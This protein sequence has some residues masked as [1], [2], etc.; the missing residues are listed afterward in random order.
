MS[1]LSK[2]SK[3]KIKKPVNIILYGQGG[4]GKS[5]FPS[6]A[7]NP[8]YLGPETEGGTAWL[9]VS[10]FPVPKT[11]AEIKNSLVELLNEKH[12]FKTL[13]FD[14]LD[15]TEPLIFQSVC[16]EAKVSLIEDAYGGFGKGYVRALD[17]WR[18]MI[19]LIHDLQVQRQMHFVAIAHAQVK[20]HTDPKTQHTWNRYTMKLNDKASA[21]W[22]ESVDA[23]LYATHEFFSQEQKGGKAKAFSTGKRILLSNWTTAYD[24]KNRMG[25]PEEIALDWDSF[26]SAWSNAQ[27]ADPKEI[28]A[29]IEEK[30]MGANEEL[31]KKVLHSIES[32]RGDAAELARIYNKL[33]TVIGG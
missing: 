11:F 5:T 22:K 1:L 26:Y 33:M 19:G 4:V 29:S 3:G 2:I 20:A 28:I 27:V 32:A 21:L 10:R 25:L 17:I 7:P 8:V 15:T 31:K 30:L 12:D 18:E 9:D 16:Q 24:A 14:S 23:M 13:V 6:K